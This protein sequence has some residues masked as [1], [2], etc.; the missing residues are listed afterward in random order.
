MCVNSDGRVSHDLWTFCA[1]LAVLAMQVACPTT[2][3]PTAHE[4][5]AEVG[6]LAAY[7]LLLESCSDTGTGAAVEPGAYD[8]EGDGDLPRHEGT[9]NSDKVR[10]FRLYVCSSMLFRIFPSC[11]VPFEQP[12]K[13]SM[14]I[15]GRSP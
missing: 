7:Q 2:K 3:A 15:P 12:G 6:R 9:Q 13:L 4:V 10:S 11:S 14:N 1:L 8:D 5:A